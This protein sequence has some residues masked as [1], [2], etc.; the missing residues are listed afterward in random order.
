MCAMPKR[1]KEGGVYYVGYKLDVASASGQY[2]IALT[3]STT[4]YAINAV[5]ITPDSA[6]ANDNF[7]L[8]HVDTT[9]TTGGRVIKQIA[10]SIYNVGGG[11]TISLDFAAMQL[12]SPGE[13]LRFTYTNT[14]SVAMP[15]YITVEAI[16]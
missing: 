10:T 6:G 7:A 8:A 13:S 16:R 3:P 14:A 12:M 15:V 11:I 1:V 5:S 9:A 4:H 2:P